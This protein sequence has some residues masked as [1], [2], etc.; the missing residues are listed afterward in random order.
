MTRF[1]AMGL[2]ALIAAARATFGDAIVFSGTG[3]DAEVT[4]ALNASSMV[5]RPA[6]SQGSAP[7]PGAIFGR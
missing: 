3:T 1:S 7:S 6:R 2:F 4:A 5:T